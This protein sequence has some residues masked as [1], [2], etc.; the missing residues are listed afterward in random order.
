[1]GGVAATLH[2]SPTSTFDL[3]V[4]HSR[5]AANIRRLLAA[6]EELEACY[7]IQ[8]QKRLRP[9]AS[10]LV[11]AGHQ[12]LITRFGPLDLLGSIG[13][14]HDYQ[15]LLPHTSRMRVGP[16]FAVRVL[17]L[18]TLIDIKSETAGEKDRAVLPVLRRILAEK[19]KSR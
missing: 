14:G 18:N 16:R 2:G 17:D 7:R 12:L 3:D 1:V 13:R 11:S 8:P 5:K 19:E 9:L 4:V 15:D 6:L 10:H